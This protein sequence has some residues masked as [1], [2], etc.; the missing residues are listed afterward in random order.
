M[1][2]ERREHAR[3]NEQKLVPHIV[4]FLCVSGLLFLVYSSFYKMW[5]TIYMFVYSS[6]SFFCT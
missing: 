5:Y 2:M 4:N 3:C 1:S 6:D